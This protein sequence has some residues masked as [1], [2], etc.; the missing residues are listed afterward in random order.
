MF[1]LGKSKF[2]G[3]FSCASETGL[4]VG[5]PLKQIG[6]DTLGVADIR[7]CILTTDGFQSSPPESVRDLAGQSTV[8]TCLAA[9]RE[10]R[11]HAENVLH[12]PL[13]IPPELHTRMVLPLISLWPK[14]PRTVRVRAFLF[15]CYASAASLPCGSDDGLVMVVML[16]RLHG[17]LCCSVIYYL[18]VLYSFRVTGSSLRINGTLV[19]SQFGDIL[20]VP[21]RLG[22]FHRNHPSCNPRHQ[23]DRP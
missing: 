21:L 11:Q 10:Y 3:A 5:Q 8:A 20:H 14:K 12:L 19:R 6:E 23:Q 7:Q 9:A 16:M 4:G 1:N 22:Y 18:S 17:C 15:S 2:N 13:T